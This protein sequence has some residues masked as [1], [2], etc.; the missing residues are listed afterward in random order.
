VKAD[1]RSARVAIGAGL[2]LPALAILGEALAPP[3]FDPPPVPEGWAYPSLPALPTAETAT[4]PQ[5][6]AIDRDEVRIPVRDTVLAGAVFAPQE[7]GRHPAVVFVHGAGR[8]SRSA[9][10]DQAEYLARSGVVALVYDKRTV[11]YSF[12]SR[13]FDLLAENALAAVRV[14]RD[15][16]EVDP[17]RVGLRGVSEGGWVVPI[18]AARSPDVA[19]AI[20]VCAPNVS[21]QSQAMWAFDDHLRRI[22]APEGF[23]HAVIR[24]LSMGEFNYSRHD[25]L[26]ALR[27][28][29]Q[30]VLALYG[31]DDRAVPV[32]QSSRI[33]A[34]ALESAG[35]AAFAIRF[36]EGANHDLRV[37]GGFAPGYL[38]TMAN[39]IV[40]LP[41][42][43][44]PSHDAPVAGSPP[45][46]ARQAIEPPSP[47]AYGTAPVLL[48]AFG[49]AAAGSL[50]GPAAAMLSRLRLGHVRLDPRH[51]ERWP[52]IRRLLRR[53]AVAGVSSELL[54]SL[55]IGLAAAFVVLETGSGAI[56]HGGWFLVRAGTLLALVLEVAAV[57][58]TV[59]AVRGGWQPSAAHAT[60]VIGVIGATGILLAAAA[61]LGVFAP[62]W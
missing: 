8:G 6:G 53:L 32:L 4:P 30:P 10:A 41:E 44:D 50:T 61:Y 2:A 25:P 45:E 34:Q 59:A 31:T 55:A 54:T 1:R 38:E 26:P 21:P 19:F 60:A 27:N 35:N 18:A 15:R 33:L 12:T 51:P 24:A 42:S 3:S 47:P 37:D 36:F 13:D 40:A 57:D 14:L 52:P 16:P 62:R 48:G 28:V 11:G 9:L 5:V 56:A 23:R 20:L 22:E 39:W 58:T 43:G 29:R 46:Q 17:A 49:L 7:P